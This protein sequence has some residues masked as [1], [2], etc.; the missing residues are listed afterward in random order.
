MK[1]A[2][3][4]VLVV[5][6]SSSCFFSTKPIALTEEQETLLNNASYLANQG[7]FDRSYG[8]IQQLRSEK[9]QNPAV[10]FYSGFLVE[11]T[12]G[13]KKA[14]IRHYINAIKM[15]DSIA[16]SER[17]PLLQSMTWFYM[18]Y[19]YERLKKTEKAEHALSA[20]FAILDKL[21]SVG[22]LQDGIGYYMLAYAYDKHN[23]KEL[24]V[25]YY[26]KAITYFEEN[27]LNYYYLRGALYNIG[28]Y[29]YNNN[30]FREAAE[31][32]KEAYE[33]EPENGHFKDFYEQWYTIAS[34]QA[35]SL[36]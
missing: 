28:L 12:K 2:C 19:S 6:L 4:A 13:D 10:E 20:A 21:N 18:A 3:W 9:V 25:D 36:E 35:R 32:W 23:Q 11:K 8:I 24:S 33:K 14:S 30:E 7:D 31:F 1:K 15:M 26:K 17:N 27:N 5:F 34:E 22:R 16:P 29:H